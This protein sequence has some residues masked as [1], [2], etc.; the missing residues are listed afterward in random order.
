MLLLN[1]FIIHVEAQTFSKSVISITDQ[2]D[3][4]KECLIFKPLREKISKKFFAETPKYNV[5]NHG[6]DLKVSSNL[7]VNDKRIFFL[8][9]ENLRTTNS[10]FLF[11]VINV[12]KKKAFVRYYFTYKDKNVEK[13]IPITIDFEKNNTT[14]NVV[15]YSI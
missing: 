9:K 12:E 4:I 7:S 8:T 5:L 15:N 2:N 3:L 13:R 10:Y 6:I 11:H 14:W 1:G